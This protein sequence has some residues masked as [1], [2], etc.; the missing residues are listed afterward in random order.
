M[1]NNLQL[2]TFTQVI[3]SSTAQTSTNPG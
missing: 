1:M 3:Y 2:L